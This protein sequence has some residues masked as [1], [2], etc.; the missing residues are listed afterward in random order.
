M[1]QVPHEYLGALQWRLI[2]PYRGGRVVA[3]AGVPGDPKTAYF[4]S[5]GGGVWKTTNAGLTW[6]PIFD[7]QPI[8]SIGAIAVAPS[9]PD[10]IYVG[11]GESDIRSALSSGDGVYK[12]EDAGRTWKH[13]GLRDTRQISKI[14][15]DPQNAHVVYVA[16]LGHAYGP[17]D[18]RGVF[19]SSDGGATWKRVL[20]KGPDIGAS[21]VAMA[22]E[23]SQIL[24]AT[25]WK[26]KRPPWSAYAPLGGPGSGLYRSVDAGATWTELKGD[27]LPGGEWGRAGVAVA[28]DGRRVYA[29]IDVKPGGGLYRSDDAGDTWKLMNDDKRLTSRG[30]YFDFVT[31]DPSNPDV[32]YVPNVAVIRSEDGGKTITIVKGEP[33]GDDYHI[34]WVD[35]KNPAHLVLGSD[36]GTNISLDRGETWSSWYNQPTAQM[37][38]VT[39]DNSFPYWVMGS[40]QDSGSIAV[41]SR[42]DHGVISAQD[43]PPIGGGES[44]TLAVDPNDSNIIYATAQYGPVI[45]YDRRT[46]LSQDVSPWQMPT[47]NTE[48]VS[49]KYRAP[50]TPPLVFSPVDKK[51]LYMGTQFVM[52][53]TDQGLHW[54]QI[55]PDLT[56]AQPKLAAGELPKP[57][58]ENSRALGYGVVFTIAPSPL[59]A[60]VIWAGSDTGLIHLTT[61]GGKTWKD[62]TPPGLSAWS[63]IS[64]IEASHFEPGEAFAAVDRHRL[65]DQR[66]YLYRTRN[67]G[68]TW[69]AVINGIGESSFLRVVREDI[70]R[71]NLLFAGTELGMY[72][73]FDDGEYWQPL[74]L[75]LPVSSVQDISIHED[76][77]VIGTHGRSMWIMDDIAPLRELDEKAI[78]ATSWLF[79]PAASY[80]V[81]NDLFLGT[82]LPPE[83]PQS[84][85]PPDGAMIDYYLKSDA[86]DVTMEISDTAGHLVRRFSSEDRP[87]KRMTL[88]IAEQW[89]PVPI[90]LEKTAG[91]HR[92]VWDLRS[93]SSG[94]SDAEE[95]TDESTPPRGPRVPPGAYSVRLTVKGASLTQSLQVKMDPRS[96]ATTQEL[97]KQFQLG[98]EMFAQAWHGR[99]GLAEVKSVQADL[100]KIEAQAMAKA[101]L[102]PKVKSVEA[103]VQK[104]VKGDSQKLGLE[105]ASGGIAAALKVVEGGDRE[106]PAQTLELFR[107]CNEALQA[108]LAEWQGLKNGELLGL[109]QELTK[110][111]LAPVKISEIEEEVEYL[112]TR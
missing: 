17:N 51:T 40:Q 57:T 2:G 50:W 16:A 82:P 89:F 11:T 54:Q 68:K 38:R 55:S 14:V 112:M 111:G 8:A 3:T 100:S 58:V 110:V 30:W 95:S 104:V 18:E 70:R 4:G 108:R 109:N 71:R 5:V 10:V 32:V 7:S 66:P 39:T 76:D 74:Q 98:Q 52:K 41:A 19:K 103:A 44:A 69:R 53:T 78:A 37:Y 107:Q 31:V 21:D 34:L 90:K 43:M 45:R 20:D 59:N 22:E 48:I 60:N 85:N 35:P 106:V 99:Q 6:T 25:L 102:L 61:D 87:A 77:L 46:S 93:N 56:G 63:K 23:N 72:V 96:H 83:E 26:T 62:V 81:D 28:P 12:S 92:F 36:Q 73:S 64:T 47:W 33:G 97:T 84:K 67:F 65:D 29:V 80:R 75:N 79:H 94:A 101:E 88:P 24:F 9:D 86:S 49:R 42:S 15:V 91:M 1:A 13:I 105:A 27:G